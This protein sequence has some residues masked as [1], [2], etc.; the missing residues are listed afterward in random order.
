[1]DDDDMRRGRPSCHKKFGEDTALLA[2][3]ALLTLA[4]KTLG[5][6][7][8]K[9]TDASRR[10]E[11]VRLLAD[12]VGSR[13]ERANGLGGDVGLRLHQLWAVVLLVAIAVAL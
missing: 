7:G 9:L 1:M 11:A 12:A 2:G 8:G 10:L 6:S 5:A 13:G 3:D 4:F